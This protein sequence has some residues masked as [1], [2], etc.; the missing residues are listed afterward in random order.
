MRLHFI[1]YFSI[2][3]H[4]K[5]VMVGHSCTQFTVYIL[6]ISR[7]AY[8]FGWFVLVVGYR[9]CI[10]MCTSV[11]NCEIERN[12]EFYIIELSSF[13]YFQITCQYSV[14]FI[15]FVSFCVLTF[16]IFIHIHLLVTM[17]DSTL[18]SSIMCIKY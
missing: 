18:V 5:I 16:H 17:G 15:C 8:G 9:P 6:C 10:T 3:D 12:C 11:T 13:I 7:K 1:V 14:H 2:T 4:L